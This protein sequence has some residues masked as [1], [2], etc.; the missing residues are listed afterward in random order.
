M[1]YIVKSA[2]DSLKYTLGIVYE[3]NVE[4]LEGDFST[5]DEIMK[6]AW[7][8]MRKIQGQ[9]EVAKMASKVVDSILKS[10]ESDEEV[11]LDVSALFSTDIKKS[12]G[13][14]HESVSDEYGDIV[15]C[16]CAPCDMNIEDEV[17]K[18]GTWLLG[19][20]WSDPMWEKVVKGDRTGYSM[21]GS[22]IRIS[23]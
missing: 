15:E 8:Y 22:G 13:D 14:M 20:V 19:V 17:I 3:P 4:D 12:L 11:T 5:E 7:G 23:V 16:Y 18:K 21:G 2:Q 9:G 1:D 6:A 10:L